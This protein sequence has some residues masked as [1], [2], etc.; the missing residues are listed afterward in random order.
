MVGGLRR[1]IL[2]ADCPPVANKALCA[3]R[4][5]WRL[6]AVV[7]GLAALVGC[8]SDRFSGSSGLGGM[9]G[10]SSGP[11]PSTAPTGKVTVAPLDAPG[12]GQP[13]GVD[14]AGRWFL[15][16]SGS[17]MCAMTFNAAPGAVEGG[18]A[19]EGGCP[20]NFFTSRQ[21]ALNQ[22]ALVIRDHNGAPLVQLASV[23]PGRF[24]GRTAAGEVIS[25]AR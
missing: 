8:S 21:W 22:G 23:G 24:E 25:L 4:T 20:G 16:A 13:N 6:S 3:R 14:M 18:I 9:G 10:P 2:M 19:P 17:G 15:A 1:V 11:P 12:S 7:A 5:A